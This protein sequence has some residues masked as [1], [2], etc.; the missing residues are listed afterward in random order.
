MQIG[1]LHVDNRIAAGIA[2]VLALVGGLLWPGTRPQD[3]ILK[4][5]VDPQYNAIQ[6]TFLTAKTRKPR[7]AWGR[8]GLVSFNPQSI[9]LKSDGP[10]FDAYV[11]DLSDLDADPS[12][13]VFLDASRRIEAGEKLEESSTISRRLDVTE[14]SFGLASMPFGIRANYMVIVYGKEATEVTGV[15]SYGGAAAE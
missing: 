14:T 6:R 9:S 8:G 11:L 3:E 5:H 7:S 12:V 4:L 2:I 1:K 10:A 15:V 13:D